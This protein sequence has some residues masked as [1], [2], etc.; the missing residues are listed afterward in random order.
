MRCRDC[1]WWKLDHI[2]P[3][4]EYYKQCFAP[5]KWDC[6]HSPD[7]VEVETIDAVNDWLGADRPLPP[8][9]QADLDKRWRAA[10]KR[11]AARPRA[12]THYDNRA[13]AKG[14]N[15]RAKENPA[16]AG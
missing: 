2:K 14:H 13:Q 6:D 1:E 7:P 12:K 15:A 4:G 11:L 9:A 16:G 3:S 5:H 8:D 10:I